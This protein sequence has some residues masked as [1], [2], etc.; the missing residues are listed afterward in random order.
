MLKETVIAIIQ[1]DNRYL[2][3]PYEIN[4]RVY[5][6][7]PRI[8]TTN[9]L[10]E[11]EEILKK[12]LFDKYSFTAKIGPLAYQEDFYEDLDV[13]SY[14]FFFVD[15]KEKD[16]PLHMLWLNKEDFKKVEFIDTDSV[17]VQHLLNKENNEVSLSNTQLEKA[18][19]T[20]ESVFKV[21]VSKANSETN[22]E[23]SCE[24]TSEVEDED[25]LY[26]YYDVDKI[27]DLNNLRANKK[28]LEHLNKIIIVL[29]HDDKYVVRKD[30]F[31]GKD[32][33][34]FWELLSLKAN[35]DFPNT[36]TLKKETLNKYGLSIE[37]I[38]YLHR[39]VNKYS[40]YYF[41]QGEISDRSIEE[42]L[43]KN[44]WILVEDLKE[45]DNYSFIYPD[46]FCKDKILG[47]E[48]YHSQTEKDKLKA[49]NFIF[50]IN[51]SAAKTD[52]FI[53][54]MNKEVDPIEIDK[55]I[56]ERIQRYEH[57]MPTFGFSDEKR[58]NLVIWKKDK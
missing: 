30:F 16:L 2:I 28:D 3:E 23:I 12:G 31:K 11:K 21:D 51:E 55:F 46:A 15:I 44:K 17:F 53:A 45:H 35:E 7:F 42:F 37:K 13:I 41:Y 52:A 9:A 10:V 36:L 40:H 1:E 26:M 38:E 4:G 57:G 5:V 33:Y 32:F 6:G 56:K 22:S 43:D 34:G 49:A 54:L 50:S 18:S 24:T 25:K 39:V 58:S 48:K 8:Y 20:I 19:L 29:K 14:S 47:I 27:A